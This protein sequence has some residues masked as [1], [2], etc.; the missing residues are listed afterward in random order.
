MIYVVGPCPLCSVVI[1]ALTD[2]E[3][4][5]LYGEHIKIHVLEEAEKILEMAK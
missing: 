5:R 4:R 1:A 3:W 2:V